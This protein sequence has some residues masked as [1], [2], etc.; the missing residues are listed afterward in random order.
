MRIRGLTL[1]L[2]LL[3]GLTG[4]A[5]CDSNPTRGLT[6]AWHFAGGGTCAGTGVTQVR[7][8]IA[9]EP[10]SQDTFDCGSGA[11]TFSDFYPGSYSVIVQGLDGGGDQTWSGKQDFTI[12]NDTTVDVAL[13][14][15]SAQN[16][17]AYLSWT[18]DAATGQAPQCGAGQT[19][20]S[21]AIYIDDAATTDLS[22]NCEDGL[23]SRQ[24]ITPYLDPGDHVIQLVAYSS[25]D[26]VTNYAQT[27]PITV[28]FTTGQAPAQNLTF[29]WRVGGVQAAWA[30]YASVGDYDSDT[31]Q[32]CGQTGIADMVLGFYASSPGDGP[33]FSL[34]NSCNASVILDNVQA[35]TWT[36][37]I[38]ACGPGGTAGQCGLPGNA[39]PVIYRED[40]ARVQPPQISVTPG[41]FFDPAS[42][43]P[44][45]V[46]LPLFHL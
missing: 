18:F 6:I 28:H 34:G 30:A 10:L 4:L 45:Q 35:G 32:P 3:A 37:Y 15:Q 23:G 41:Q 2:S 38:D 26:L 19:L 21:V 31:R 11:V 46:F 22:Y 1:W 17:V 14:P 24:V 39:A 25:V 44:F 36:P 43:V 9:G 27:N 42:P 40:P 33:A 8:V 12:R 5:G 20:D 13:Q 7:I 16:A 29:H